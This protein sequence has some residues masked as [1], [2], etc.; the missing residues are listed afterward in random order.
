MRPKT[1]SAINCTAEEATVLKKFGGFLCVGSFI[2]IW[3]SSLLSPLLFVAAIIHG[4]Y[5]SA[6]I[7]IVITIASYAP[8]EKGPVSRILTPPYSD[9]HPYYYKEFRIEFEGDSLPSPTDPQTF[10]AIH[11]HGAFCI[12]W[13]A[14]FTNAAMEHVRFCFSPA[15]FASPFFRLFSRC[16]GDPGSASRSA[17][18]GYLKNG[19]HLALPPGG[20]EGQWLVGMPIA[21]CLLSERFIRN[22]LAKLMC[23]V[24][25]LYFRFHLKKPRL[26]PPHM[27]VSLSRSALALLNCV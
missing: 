13:S 23:R 11:P 19:E 14:L 8:W 22:G 12:G 21:L 16:V 26:L 20:F 5:I 24:C 2:V 1:I 27:T 4:Y 17:M 10:Y 6:A 25:I 7:L 18:I 15:L 9:I 3:V